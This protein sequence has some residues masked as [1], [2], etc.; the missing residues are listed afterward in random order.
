MEVAVALLVLTIIEPHSIFYHKYIK[1]YIKI[2]D[3]Y[4]LEERENDKRQVLHNLLNIYN[5]YP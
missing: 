5:F 3:V 1:N 2:S 4:L